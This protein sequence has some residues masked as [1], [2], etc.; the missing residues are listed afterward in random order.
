VGP[1]GAIPTCA[2]RAVGVCAV[3]GVDAERG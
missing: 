1:G 3:A 2:G